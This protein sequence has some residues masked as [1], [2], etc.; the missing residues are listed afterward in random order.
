MKIATYHKMLGDN[1]TFYKGDVKQFIF[2][3]I[4]N[5]CLLELKKHIPSYDWQKSKEE[6]ET[7]IKT[8]HRTKYN[9]FIEEYTKNNHKSVA[10]VEVWLKHYIDY[11]K[12]KAYAEEP[13]F[14]RIY[15]TTLFTFYW[16]ITIK[17]IED[18]KELVKTPEELKVGGVMAS[19]L[20]DEIEI[21]TGVKTYFR[22][23]GQAR[24]ARPQ[25]QR[26]SKNNN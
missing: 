25:N 3:S 19:L 2:N 16:K 26:C 21:E 12:K 9:A 1:V 5:N 15:V 11:Y 17:A 6:I 18:A 22:S 10:L 23:F 4:V 20:T 14:D 13:E 24:N 8:G 7:L